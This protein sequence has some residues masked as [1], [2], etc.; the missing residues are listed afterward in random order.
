MPDYSVIL[1]RDQASFC[2][3][4]FLVFADGTSEP[5]HGHNYK[6]EIEIRGPLDRN[7]LVVDFCVVK[8]IVQRVCGELDSRTLLPGRS[9]RLK[10][11]SEE[12]EV[13]ATIGKRRYVVP[14]ADVVV[15]PITNTSCELIAGYLASR[16]RSELRAKVKPHRPLTLCIRLEEAPGDVG[17]CTV[18]L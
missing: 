6:A 8:P 10:V 17:T 3:A 2:A 9:R 14:R 12:G 11:R 7:G 16:V 13:V 5:L 1:E 4:H 18:G 15:L